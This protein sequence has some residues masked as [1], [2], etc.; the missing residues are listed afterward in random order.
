MI[1]VI[2][3]DD[4]NDLIDEDNDDLF[5]QLCQGQINWKKNKETI[6]TEKYN[7]FTPHLKNPIW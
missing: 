1:M 2:I 6:R 4:S 3:Y 7:C 5:Q